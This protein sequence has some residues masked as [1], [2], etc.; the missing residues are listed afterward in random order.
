M[1]LYRGGTLWRFTDSGGP[2][3]EF[4]PVWSSNGVDLVFSRGD[5]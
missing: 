4:C 5:D 2:E 1:D 3:A